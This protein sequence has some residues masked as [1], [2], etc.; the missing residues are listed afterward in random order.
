MK[1]SGIPLRLTPEDRNILNS[2]C[3]MLNGLADYLGTGYE[4]VLHS[5]ED[6]EHSA[7]CVLNSHTDRSVGAPITELG[8]T[9]LERIHEREQDQDQIETVCYTS[10]NQEGKPLRSC[11]IAIRG[12]GNRIIGLLCINF[13]MDTPLS[14]LIQLFLPGQTQKVSE[15][16]VQ[17]SAEMIRNTVQ[18]AAAEADAE[19]LADS[20]TRNREIVRKLYASGI[21]NIKDAVTQVADCLGISRNTVYLH[22]RHCKDRE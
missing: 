13:Y 14:D 17:N 1:L 22:L 6:L 4:L 11:T 18:R 7:I 12:S 5:L 19:G 9:M 2:Y 10:T 20:T 21:F 8:L 16:Y 15:T 3:H